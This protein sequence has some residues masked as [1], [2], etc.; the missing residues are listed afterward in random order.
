MSEPSVSAIVRVHNGEDHV[1]ETIAAILAQTRPADEVLVIDDGST[2]GTPS[3]L[4]G[5]GDAVR[6]VRQPNGGLA[7]AFDRAVAEARCDYVANCDADDLWEPDKLE[8][9][10]AA[11]RRH[12]EI[13]VAFG[14]ARYF[15]T[16]EGAFNTPYSGDGLLEPRSLGREL[17]RADR[18][19]VSSALIRLSL[20]RDLAPFR[21]AASPCEDYDFW[22]RALAAGAVFFQDRATLVRYRVHDSQL[23]D[24]LLTMHEREREVHR[25][26]AALPGSRAL[27]RRVEARDLSNI[28]RALSDLDRAGDARRAFLA[29]FRRRPN[30]RMLVWAAVLSTPASVRRPLSRGLVAGKRAVLAPVAQVGQSGR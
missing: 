8:R 22:L 9:Q 3:V 16:K 18:I 30:P 10:L 7:S 28:G 19:C 21:R 6:V 17:Y 14:A 2:D 11:Q 13:D 29:S 20:A 25:F 4:A 27:V 5:F 1:A 23:S 26:N 12:P 24:N 15:G